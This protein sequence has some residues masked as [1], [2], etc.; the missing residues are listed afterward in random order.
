MEIIQYLWFLLQNRIPFSWKQWNDDLAD[1]ERYEYEV[2]H[3]LPH[4]N[5]L[6]EADML[7]SSFRTPDLN[8]EVTLFY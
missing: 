7:F 1:I 6:R 8:L 3:L 4:G 5:V 2:Y